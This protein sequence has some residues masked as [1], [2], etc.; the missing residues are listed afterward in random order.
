[1]LQP[2]SS[3]GTGQMQLSPGLPMKK[4]VEVIANPTRGVPLLGGD[5]VPGM[6]TWEK[7]F[8]SLILEYGFT[9]EVEGVYPGEEEAL[10]Y[11]RAGYQEDRNWLFTEMCNRKVDN[12]HQLK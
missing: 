1:M 9:E 7:T 10:G 8:S 12:D 4:P 2:C 5:L 6:V 3:V 11:R